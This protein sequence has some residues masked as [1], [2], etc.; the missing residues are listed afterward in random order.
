MRNEVSFAWRQEYWDIY[1][2]FSVVK[3]IRVNN[4]MKIVQRFNFSYPDATSLN[5]WFRA[6][7]L[8]YSTFHA[9]CKIL[10]QNI[11]DKLLSG[12]FCGTDLHAS[13]I[14]KLRICH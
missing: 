5:V 14:Q 12:L 13:E 11:S 4:S 3:D 7:I 1:G 9:R 6:R 8:K 2:P 10:L